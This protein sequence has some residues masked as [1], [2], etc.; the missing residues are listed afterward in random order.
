MLLLL[1]QLLILLSH[2]LDFVLSL[3]KPSLEIVFFA[4]NNGNLVLHVAEVEGL[5]L[6]FLLVGN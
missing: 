5:L 6:K 1:T 2:H 3:E 4:S